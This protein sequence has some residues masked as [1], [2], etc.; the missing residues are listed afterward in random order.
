MGNPAD[1]QTVHYDYAKMETSADTVKVQAT[2]LHSVL[3]DTVRQAD[4]LM[5]SWLGQGSDGFKLTSAKYHQIA[6]DN[7]TCLEACVQ[8]IREAAM[9]MKATDK[10][11]GV[12]ITQII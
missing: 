2:R 6:N 10:N 11:V 12:G 8:C 4:I 9:N 3:E 5:T 7:N 1:G